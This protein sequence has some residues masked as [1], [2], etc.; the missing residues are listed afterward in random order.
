MFGWS[1]TTDW[2][3]E[4]QR[5]LYIR[6]GTNCQDVNVLIGIIIIVS[7]HT[8]YPQCILKVMKALLSCNEMEDSHNKVDIPEIG[9]K[10]N[11]Q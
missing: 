1:Q 7:V 5:T 4:V 9:M 11:L 8:S 6:T 2:E 10:Y 3:R